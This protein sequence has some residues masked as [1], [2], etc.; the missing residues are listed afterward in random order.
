MVLAPYQDD[1]RRVPAIRNGY[2]LNP[3]RAGVISGNTAIIIDEQDF[4]ETTST[5]TRT[6]EKLAV[7]TVFNYLATIWYA[8]SYN[9]LRRV[10]DDA[11]F[12]AYG[13]RW[14]LVA[15]NTIVNIAISSFHAAEILDLSRRDRRWHTATLA[16][17]ADIRYEY[18][19]III[20]RYKALDRGY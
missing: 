7:D 20:D 13:R 3:S 8:P 15:L 9:E 6:Q 10:A 4:V 12:E 2:R 18:R 19:Q 1:D 16:E 11:L 14:P 17:R 5:L